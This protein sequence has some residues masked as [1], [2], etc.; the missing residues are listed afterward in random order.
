MLEW[1]MQARR[2]VAGLRPCVRERPGEEHPTA[3][4]H[5]VLPA[6]E[7]VRNWRARDP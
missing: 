5:K 6:I 7:L 2:F 1:G 4:G 3:A